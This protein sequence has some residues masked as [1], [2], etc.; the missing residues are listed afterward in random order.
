M[1]RLCALALGLALTLGLVWAAPA[2]AQFQPNDDVVVP[3]PVPI[4]EFVNCSDPGLE[5]TEPKNP[6]KKENGYWDQGKVPA[7]LWTS[8]VN[9]NIKAGADDT[10]GKFARRFRRCLARAGMPNAWRRSGII[11]PSEK[12]N[13][14]LACKKEA[15]ATES[16]EVEF[17]VLPRTDPWADRKAAIKKALDNGGAATIVTRNGSQV[18]SSSVESIDCDAGTMVIRN[19]STTDT[20]TLTVDDTGKITD[21]DPPRAHYDGAQIR[22]VTV[23]CKTA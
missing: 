3:V 18:H 1:K 4:E 12:Y 20:H 19:P 10:G 9:A 8:L 14:M 2:Q 13:K 11:V 6:Y 23:E 7:C 22:A 15:R 5:T 16:V 21:V 17:K